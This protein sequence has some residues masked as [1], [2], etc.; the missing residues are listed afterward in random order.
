MSYQVYVTRGKFWAENDGFEISSAEWLQIVEADDE[1]RR[2]EQNG[3]YSADFIG[4]D[5]SND[6]WIDWAEGNLF[7]GYPDRPL[8]NALL[9]LATELGAVIQGEDGEIYR[10]VDDFPEVKH[11]TGFSPGAMNRRPAYQRREIAWTFVVIVVI[12]AAITAV[13]VL[14]LW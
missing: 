12:A 11:L 6:Q 8:Q 9:R 1:L 3:A 5:G 14:G 7:T 10:D 13:N 4:P 2:N